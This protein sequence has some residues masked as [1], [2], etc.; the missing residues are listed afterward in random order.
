MDT[1]GIYRYKKS[2]R[3]RIRVTRNNTTYMVGWAEDFPT[4]L[5]M[6]DDFLIAL[7]LKKANKEFDK[8]SK[9]WFEHEHDKQ[10]QRFALAHKKQ[11]ELGVKSPYRYIMIDA[12]VD[13][14]INYLKV[15]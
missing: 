4:A 3:Y 5:K 7:E 1:R 11:T 8:Y 13:L 9:E 15:T 2:G 10:M 12:G 6:R 14:P